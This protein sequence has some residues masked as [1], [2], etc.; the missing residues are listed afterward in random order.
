VSGSQGVGVVL[1]GPSF[2]CLVGAKEGPPFAKMGAWL[3]GVRWGSRAR[4]AV[5][6]SG[7]GAKGGGGIP[8]VCH[9]VLPICAQRWGATT[10]VRKGEERG[11]P[12]PHTWRTGRSADG[13]GGRRGEGHRES[14][15][16]LTGRTLDSAVM[17]TRAEMYH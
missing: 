4:C 5:Q 12:R 1:C 9:P 17:T 16:I 3:K 7:V 8:F 14:V 15:T 13:E 6:V 11:C 2:P 10:P